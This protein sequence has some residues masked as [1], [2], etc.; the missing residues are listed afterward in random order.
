MLNSILKDKDFNDE[1]YLAMGYGDDKNTSLQ[2]MIDEMI[3]RAAIVSKHLYHYEVLH[4]DITIKNGMITG[5]G[6]SFNSGSI[7]NNQL[8]GSKKIAIFVVTLG[9]EFDCELKDLF[10]QGETIKAFIFDTVGSVL[11]ERIADHMEL[12]LGDVLLKDDLSYTNRFSPGYCGWHVKEQQILFSLLP[13]NCC[14]I[15]LNGSSLMT[16]IKSI[17]GIIGIG[18]GLTKKD[19]ACSL[20]DMTNCYK[21]RR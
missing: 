9:D 12:E 4:H 21:R 11:V 7:I 5:E 14:G 19:Y 15:S 6:F 10:E 20:C 18:K 1:I 13:D 3:D 2:P 16:P 17:S 8:S